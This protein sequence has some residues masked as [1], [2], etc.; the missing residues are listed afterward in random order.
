MDSW[1]GKG[2]AKLRVAGV[3]VPTLPREDLEKM[4][5]H[6]LLQQYLK[7]TSSFVLSSLWLLLFFN[8]NRI[9]NFVGIAPELL[10]AIENYLINSNL[11]HFKSKKHKTTVAPQ[12]TN[13]SCS[14]ILEKMAIFSV[15]V[16]E[17]AV[18]VFVTNTDLANKK[19]AEHLCLGTRLF[20]NKSVCEQ[21]YDCTRKILF[22]LLW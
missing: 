18:I 7:Y 22:M 21:R 11:N 15:G 5:A 13:I 1:M 17:M 4:I 19:N 10:S 16:G 2:P 9:N 14:P 20:T 12:L 6:F 3:A 8:W